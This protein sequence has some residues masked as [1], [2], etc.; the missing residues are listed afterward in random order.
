M[1]ANFIGTANTQGLEEMGDGEG[2]GD[3]EI[4]ENDDS[5]PA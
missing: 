1:Q 4:Q 5:I 2:E 3:G